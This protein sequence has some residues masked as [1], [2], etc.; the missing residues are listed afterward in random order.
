MLAMACIACGGCGPLVLR[1]RPTSLIR[2]LRARLNE[3]QSRRSVT[4]CISDAV[5]VPA[6]IG[7]FRP[8]VVFPSWALA[9]IPP[10]NWTRFCCMSWRILRR[11]DD[12]TNLAQK[13]LKAILFFH[14][15]VWFIES[16]LDAGA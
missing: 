2:R 11:Y 1:L 7:Y 12:W 4:L 10:Q 5:R 13:L 6:A 16:R 14:P 9:E 15:A 3:I 8:M